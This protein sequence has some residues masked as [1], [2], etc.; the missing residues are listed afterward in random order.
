LVKVR[1]TML[2]GSCLRYLLSGAFVDHRVKS[3]IRSA[4]II[5][6]IQFCSLRPVSY[7]SAGGEPIADGKLQSQQ[8]IGI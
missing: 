7:F 1:H 5:P 3:N 6:L 4:C 2:D 8:G